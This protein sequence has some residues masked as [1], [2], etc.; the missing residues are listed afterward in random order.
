LP[1]T[2]AREAQVRKFGRLNHQRT[3]SGGIVRIVQER[4]LGLGKQRVSASA[5][6]RIGRQLTRVTTKGADRDDD[7]R[8]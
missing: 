4:Q 2:E 6:L 7:E 3:S 5:R 8:G 1:Y